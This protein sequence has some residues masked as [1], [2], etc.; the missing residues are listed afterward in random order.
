[1]KTI[2]LFGFAL[3]SLSA[4][5]KVVLISPGQKVTLEC[6]V[7]TFKTLQWHQGNDLI[8][9]V[10]MSGLPRKGSAKII[11]RT[12]VRNTDLEIVNVKEEDTGTFICTADRKR[13][14]QT[15]LVVSVWDNSHCGVKDGRSH[16][17]SL[18]SVDRSAGIWECTFSHAGV[19]HKHNLI[20]K[21]QEPAPESPPSPSQGPKP[22]PTPTCLDCGPSAVTPPPPLVL[23]G[24]NWWIWVAVGL[25]CL[26]VV[27]LLVI[28]IVLCKRFK[29]KKRK[30]TMKNGRQQLQP[31]KYCQCNC[32]AAAAKP[33]QGRRREKQPAARL[34]PLLKL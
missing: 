19:T 16:S 22:G 20:R 34:Q 10:S 1:M 18:K 27:F 21:V 23:L 11:Q 2:V 7:K 15:L 13:E 14:E 4:A 3:A 29:R 32:P 31:K 30:I 24:L 17:G 6:G 9:S 5:S 12:K 33:R 26:V 28:V 25:G 8:H